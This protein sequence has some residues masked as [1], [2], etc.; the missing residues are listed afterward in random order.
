MSLRAWICRLL[1]VGVGLVPQQLSARAPAPAPTTLR[2]VPTANPSITALSIVVAAVK[3]GLGQ[4]PPGIIVASAPLTSD[5]KA[6]RSGALR[7]RLL[8]LVASSIS[9]PSAS[10]TV[11]V[12]DGATATA[13]ERGLPGFV[14]LRPEV[15]AG[16]LALTVEA[17]GVGST[18]WSRAARPGATLQRQVHAEARLD[19]QLRLYLTP[20]RI[21]EPRVEKFSGADRGIV[22]LACGDVDADGRSEVV[23]MSRRRL[24]IARLAGGRVV[25]ERDVAW[26]SLSGIAPVPLREPL[27]IVTLVARDDGPGMWIDASLSDRDQSVRLDDSFTVMAKSPRSLVPFGSGSACVRMKSMYLDRELRSCWGESVVG[28]PAQLPSR[29][30]AVASARIVRSDGTSR[31]WLA[32]RGPA[33]LRLHAGATGYALGQTGAQVAIGDLDQDGQPDVVS[34]RD[35]QQPRHDSVDVRSIASSGLVEPRFTLPVLAG[36]D[37]VAICPVDDAGVAP[38]VL[39]SGGEIWLIR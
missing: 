33:G 35:V 5:V 21:G 23:S 34:T 26:A 16:R 38:V 30:D 32:V 1:F 28:L 10:P 20:L 37:A 31:R 15:R 14:W 11:S 2:T 27:G 9:R 13:R 29:A 18:V 3:R 19:A 6:P 39:A 22:A 17:Y 8:Q 4:L 36:V 7:M 12:L 25:R 24:L